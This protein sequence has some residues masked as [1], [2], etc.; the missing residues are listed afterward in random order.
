MD[1]FDE[2][3]QVRVRAAGTPARR[4]RHSDV[5]RFMTAFLIAIAFS[6]AT[7]LFITDRPICFYDDSVVPRSPI[8]VSHIRPAARVYLVPIEDFPVNRAAAIAEHFRAKFGVRIEVAPRVAWPEGAYVERR[9][10]MNSAA[11]LSRLESIYASRGHSAV[12]IGLTTRDMFNPEVNWRY[13]FSYR[14]S[15]RVAVV[16]PARMSGGCMGLVRADESRI[17]ARL[18]KMVGKN[19]GI[20]YFGLPLS[21]DPASMLYGDIG[22]PQELD[23]MSEMY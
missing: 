20:L 2:R 7:R 10:Q 6:V 1:P 11:M 17:M 13:V 19:I 8:D 16:S 9:R 21:T 12:A 18:R 15:K 23:A 4:R 14:S 22:G 3:T 5:A